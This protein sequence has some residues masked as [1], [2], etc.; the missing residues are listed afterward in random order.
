MIWEA[1]NLYVLGIF[2]RTTLWGMLITMLFSVTM[3]TMAYLFMAAIFL[4]VYILTALMHLIICK[5]RS[6]YSMGEF[7]FSTLGSDLISPFFGISTF[8]A[9][10]F[11]RWIIHD[12][13]KFHNF[14]DTIQVVFEGICGITIIVLII[15]N[16]M[17][18]IH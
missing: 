12:D 11:R 16:I 8:I 3:K 18:L 14:I 6:G 4:G 1:N 9:V 7:Y 2:R 17:L 5:I 10:L 15:I 13:T